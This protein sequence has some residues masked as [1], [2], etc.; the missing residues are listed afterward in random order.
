MANTDNFSGQEGNLNKWL[1]HCKIVGTM[2]KWRINVQ[3]EGIFKNS[4]NT[5]K[6]WVLNIADIGS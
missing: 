6:P 4:T 2:A 1:S 5:I 3:S